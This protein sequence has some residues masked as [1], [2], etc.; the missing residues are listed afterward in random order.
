MNFISKAEVNYWI[1]KWADHFY[2]YLC[3]IADWGHRTKT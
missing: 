2:F 3:G 1:S